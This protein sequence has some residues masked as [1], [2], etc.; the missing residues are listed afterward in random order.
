VSD[1]GI[2]RLKSV[3]TVVGG[4]VVYDALK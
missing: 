2:K 4:R 3:L 1:E